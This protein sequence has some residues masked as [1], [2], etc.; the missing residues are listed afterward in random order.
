MKSLIPFL[1]FFSTFSFSQTSFQK[2]WATYYGNENTII[3]DTAIDKD[4][5]LF[6]VG[7]VKISDGDYGFSST[8]GAYQENYS[9]GVSDGFIT[10]FNPNGE[11][12]WATFFGG[13]NGDFIDSISLDKSNNIYVIGYT[14]SQNN[15]ATI[16]SFQS[17]NNSAT[18]C[19][20]SKFNSNGQLLWSTFYNGSSNNAISSISINDFLLKSSD[21]Q[22]DNNNFLYLYSFCIENGKATNNAFQTE[23]NNNNILLSK[24]NSNGE[25]VWATYYGI[26]DSEITSLAVN[27][28]G[29]YIGGRNFD[30]EFEEN[31]YFGTPNSHQP[32]TES[33][34]SSYLSKFNTDGQRIWSTYIG[35]QG[36]DTFF[37]D[38]LLSNSVVV[39]GEN[40]Y[41]AL[42]S[43]R[44]IGIA[45]ENSFQPSKN[46]FSCPALI[47]FNTNG[48]KQWGTYYGLDP[49]DNFL[50]TQIGVSVDETG[51]PYLFGTTNFQNNISTPTTFQDTIEDTYFNYDA[52]VA[53]FSPSGER[54]WGTYFGGNLLETAATLHVYGSKFYLVGLTESTSGITTENSFQPNF[55]NTNNPLVN[56]KN[57]IFLARFDPTNLSNE[58]FSVST[59]KVFPNPARDSF[60]ITALESD[61]LIELYDL[62]GK[63]IDKILTTTLDT[64]VATNNIS[65]GIYLA[66]ITNSKNEFVVQKIVIE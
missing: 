59:V 8:T 37:Y 33:C 25:R 26:N 5:N 39:Y 24:F 21:L 34:N 19:F 27:E 11:V 62:L 2:T 55:I 48:V 14:S 9:G 49:L 63:K 7:N 23:K 22:I 6:V 40:L 31:S 35:N 16:N 20:F 12:V 53:K 32:I 1:L 64:K 52:F 45:T 60:T 13:E 58:E 54:I 50:A 57:N 36:E 65:R 18:S 17:T 41:L 56:P 47:K 29:L 66:K 42:L 46:Y 3:S 51:N 30:C 4:G 28:T 44:D 15:I 38:D 10:K 43:G 61:L